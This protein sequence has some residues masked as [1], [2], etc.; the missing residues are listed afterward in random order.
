VYDRKLSEVLREFARTLATDFPIQRILDHL[1]ERMLECLP[2]TAAGVTLIAEGQAPRYIAASDAN[3]LRFERLQTEFG[4]GPCLAA[5]STSQPV[6]VADLARDGRFSRFGP[7]AAAAGL[8]AVFAFPLLHDNGSLGAL[9]LYRNTPGP[10]SPDD[11]AAAQ[12]LADVTVAYLLNAKAREDA[13]TTSDQFRQS[14]LHDP[15]TGLPNRLLLSQRIEH[16]AQRAR[17]THSMAAILFADVDRFKRVN[18]THGHQVGDELLLAVAH[19]LTALVRPGDTLC[20]YAGDEFVF[21]CEDLHNEADAELLANRVNE[22]FSTPFQLG[23]TEIKVTA[24]I[25]MAFAGRGE[26]ISDQLVVVADTAMYQAKRKGGAAHQ[27]IDLREATETQKRRRL[28]VELRCALDGGELEL[29]YQPVVTSAAGL[30]TG[31]EALLRWPAPARGPVAPSLAVSV[32]EQ[33]GLINSLGEW[34]LDRACQ[35]HAGWPLNHSGEPLD[36]AVNVSAL[37]LMT[38]DF[39]ATVAQVLARHSTDPS[40]VVLEMTEYILIEDIDR[41][42]TVL[43]DLKTLGIRIALDDFGTG[44]SS[45]NYLRRLPIDVVKID[46]GFIAD[47]GAATRGQDIVAAV[48]NLAHV[49]GLTVVAEGVETQ[50]QRD[51]V[52]AVGCE[53]AQGF[54]FARPMTAAAFGELVGSF[55]TAL[56]CL[57]GQAGRLPLSADRV[58]AR[59]GDVR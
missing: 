32:A 8:A 55:G 23:G 36:L 43:A 56:V 29:A 1:V 31:V 45:L 34:V 54:Y 59:T 49:L 18:D 57:P 20:R 50:G 46:Q 10:L 48:T 22:A 52:D 13:R 27:V 58:R 44:F 28:E 41:A 30:V 26:G 53:L 25:G 42:M 40:A 24:S 38:A 3:A 12:T 39:V 5:F 21:L 4:E 47:I 33:S 35:D 37:Q 15:L 9:D 6:L 11:I 51:A 14:A 19:R 7:S 2:I 17:R 16:A